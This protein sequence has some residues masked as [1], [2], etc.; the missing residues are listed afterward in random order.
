M[1][2][3]DSGAGG[4]HV[5]SVLTQAGHTATLRTVPHL[6]PFGDKEPQ[7][8]Y[9]TFISFRKEVKDEPIFCACN[10]MSLVLQL[11]EYDFEVNRVI[12]TMPDLTE[13]APICYATSLTARLASNMSPHFRGRAVPHL[14]QAAEDLW[15][16][17]ITEEL[18]A[19]IWHKT[20]H[21]RIQLGSTHLSYLAHRLGQ[22]IY[23]VEPNYL[24]LY[25]KLT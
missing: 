13:N 12:P 16:N 1:I 17:R 6:F 10:T 3:F 24:K 15:H 18:A 4:Y 20:V 21:H 14:V 22:T 5:L 19:E 7:L 11:Y 23:H 8:L 9:S 2:V 25:E